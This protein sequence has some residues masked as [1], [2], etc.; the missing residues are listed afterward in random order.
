M[1]LTSLETISRTGSSSSTT[2]IRSSFALK[3]NSFAP[4]VT[5]IL[6]GR[7][8]NSEGAEGPY[9]E[10]VF[11]HPFQVDRKNIIFIG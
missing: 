5:S 3:R 7:M 10:K 9:Q 6:H 11:N 2:K 4:L 1:C 8:K